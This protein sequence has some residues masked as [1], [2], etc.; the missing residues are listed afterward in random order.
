M[1]NSSQMQESL[2]NGNEIPSKPIT[3]LEK[4]K[5]FFS[6]DKAEI[7]KIRRKNTN[8]N[9]N[10][11][12][13][14][15]AE[16][17]ENRISLKEGTIKFHHGKKHYETGEVK[18]QMLRS[19]SLWSLGLKKENYESSIYIAYLA[20]ITNAANYIYIENQF[21]IS[22]TAGAPVKNKIAD[23]LVSRIKKAALEKQDFKVFILMPLLPV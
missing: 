11:Q 21:F 17:S 15:F 8:P 1:A 12:K 23:A 19:A 13:S 14:S 2:K 3:K 4:L 22:S 9:Q 7:E 16:N 20:L 6:R 5:A 18:C 10:S